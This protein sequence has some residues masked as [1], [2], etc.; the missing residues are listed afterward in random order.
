M[1]LIYVVITPT[2]TSHAA[3][4]GDWY[5]DLVFYLNGRKVVVTNPQPETTLLSYLRRSG[6][7]GSKLGCG[8]GE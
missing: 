4:N 8:E 6:L 7:T 1:H 2:G 3:T 5:H